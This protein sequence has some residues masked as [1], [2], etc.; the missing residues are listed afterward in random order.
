MVAGFC[1][2][3]SVLAL[4]LPGHGATDYPAGWDADDMDIMSLADLARAVLQALGATDGDL[5]GVGAG[6]AVQVELA[7]QWPAIAASLTLIAA[8]D[9]TRDP[10]LQAGLLASYTPPQ[11]DSY[12]GYLLRAW[13]EARD[14]LLFFPWYERRRSCAVADSPRLDPEFLQHRTVDALLA[15]AAG[16]AVR[17]AEIRYPLLTRLMRQPVTARLAAPL[18]E[19]RHAH[20]RGLAASSREFLNL[21]RDADR[22]GRDLASV[23]LPETP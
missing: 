5:V 8:V 1:A 9:V 15:G 12:G 21:S 13:H 3:R 7:S 16:V 2:A 11:A 22:W 17:K 6:A 20:A 4:E 18:W 23:A 14:H 19:P 10:A